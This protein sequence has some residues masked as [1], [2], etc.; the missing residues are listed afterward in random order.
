LTEK[1]KAYYK[2]AGFEKFAPNYTKETEKVKIQT[3]PK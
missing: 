1:G 3:P 2:K